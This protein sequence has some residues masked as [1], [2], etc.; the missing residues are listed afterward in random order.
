MA[1]AGKRWDGPGGWALKTGSI[2]SLGLG[3]A[4][5]LA[6]RNPMLAAGAAASALAADQVQKAVRDR[7]VTDITGLM[8]PASEFESWYK[9]C[10]SAARVRAARL[11]GSPDA[12]GLP[13]IDTARSDAT[14]AV[15]ESWATLLERE[16][17][18][19]AEKSILGYLRLL[20]DL[21]VY[22]L[23]VW[24]LY[25][26]ITGFVAGEYVGVDFLL[27]A[28][29]ILAAYLF[30]VRLVVR[31]GLS[32]RANR[33]LTEVIARSRAALGHRVE[34]VKEDLQR[35]RTERLASLGYIA[36]LEKEWR[37]HLGG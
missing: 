6:T 7:R 4:A 32:W 25:K 30:A 8:P 35:L 28:V 22:A 26:V 24:V 29:L 18:A 15:H 14:T 37:A 2:G 33:L 11:V 9:E 3:S 17:P 34:L 20:L 1:E 10:L 16:L 31:R 19:A 13:S 12:L 23:A 36:R 5:A 21:P 27:N